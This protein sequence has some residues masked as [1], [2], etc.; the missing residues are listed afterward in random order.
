MMKTFSKLSWTALL[1]VL[2]FASCK[3]DIRPLDVN[4]SAVNTLLAPVDQ[5]DIKL[6]PRTGPNLV[7]K[8]SPA[9]TPDSGLILYQVVFDKAGG[10]FSKPIY[11]KVSD[12]SGVQTQATITQKEMNKIASLAGIETSSTGKLEWAVLASKAAN[13]KISTKTR[14]LQ[15]ERPAGFAELPDSLYLT[16]TATEAGGDITKAIPLKET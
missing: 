14:T 5:Q 16:G 15:I 1:S 11:E 12:G 8:W 7:F 6:E 10:N 9:T 2:V 13:A 4:L 3:K